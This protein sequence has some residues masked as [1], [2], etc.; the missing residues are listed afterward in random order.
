M[1]G[2]GCWLTAMQ[3]CWMFASWPYIVAKVAAWLFIVSW[4]AE[5][6]APKFAIDSLYDAMEASLS[7]AFIP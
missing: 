5:Y 6:A 2:G 3:N 4:V 1:L 7:M